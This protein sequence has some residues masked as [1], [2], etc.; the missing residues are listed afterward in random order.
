MDNKTCKF[1]SGFSPWVFTTYA[2]TCACPYCMIPKVQE[3][4][5]PPDTFEEML[6]ITEKLFE[7]GIYDNA[8][9][10]LSGGEPLLAWDNYASLVTEYR[11]KY[12]GQ[13]NFGLL[14]NLTVLKD[15]MIEWMLKNR[16]GIQASLD[17]LK[18]SK[19]LKT[20]EPS[21]PIV[22]ENL[23]RL[24]EAKVN[25]TVNTVY[26][27]EDTRSLDDLVDYICQLNPSQWGF[28]ASFTIQ[29]DSY[30]EEA[31]AFIKLG[32]LRLRDNGFDIRNKFRFYNEVINKPGQTCQAGCGLFAIGP[33]LEV[34]S[35]QQ[36][37]DKPPLGYFDGNV[38][39]LLATSA[40]NAYFRDRVL[41]PQ[42]TDCSVLHWCRGGCRAIH[43][44]NA[45]AVDI[46][47]RIKQEIV[48]YILKNTSDRPPMKP[49]QKKCLKDK[50]S[51]GNMIEVYAGS[52]ELGEV[53]TPSL[54]FEAK[55]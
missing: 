25:F 22:M 9:F 50:A 42:C 11:E 23:K 21:A 53:E 4:A 36:Q 3:Q 49:M 55:E 52:S 28:S 10:R 45:K 34:W 44:S 2:C 30:L 26:N 13:M 32:I 16:V 54:G 39:E 18:G 51:L 14:S 12:P 1:K 27:A 38:K 7:K 15:D 20:G 31:L 17:D 48:N 6:K 37:V 47:C 33:N 24:K 8:S 5:M 29:D 40:A 46:T 43:E 35:C 19:I 41:L